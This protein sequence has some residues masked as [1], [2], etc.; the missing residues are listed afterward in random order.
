MGKGNAMDGEVLSLMHW[1]CNQF[2]G[3]PLLRFYDSS[4]YRISLQ[5]ENT[6]KASIGSIVNHENG[7]ICQNESGCSPAKASG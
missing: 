5:R 1:R 7:A 2:F 4:S 6:S 3:T